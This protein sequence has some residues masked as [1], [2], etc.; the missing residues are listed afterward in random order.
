MVA[1]LKMSRFLQ[2]S[3]KRERKVSMEMLTEELEKILIALK[4]RFS[5]G[6][7]EGYIEPS[8]NLIGLAFNDATDS[9]SPFNRGLRVVSKDGNKII[10]R[11]IL[12]EEKG[13]ISIDTSH[14]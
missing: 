11:A 13:G 10:S 12:I 3:H 1:E 6:Q 5:E 7:K 8:E 4:A 2:P 14:W 9:F